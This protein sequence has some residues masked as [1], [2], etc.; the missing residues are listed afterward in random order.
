MELGGEVFWNGGANNSGTG[1]EV[2]WNEGVINTGIR[3]FS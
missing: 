1:G 3:R 2:Y